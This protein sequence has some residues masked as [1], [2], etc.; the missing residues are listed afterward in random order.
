[1]TRA[2]TPSGSSS[3]TLGPS[4]SRSSGST[5]MSRRGVPLRAHGGRRRG[6]GSR[7][8]TC[9][10]SPTSR[11]RT[12]SPASLLQPL[13]LLA[14]RPRVPAGGGA[15]RPGRC[16]RLDPRH[17]HGRTHHRPDQYGRIRPRADR[18][19]PDQAGVC[20]RF[21]RGLGRRG[22]VTRRDLLLHVAELDRWSASCA[23]VDEAQ[24]VP[25]RAAAPPRRACA[26]RP[27]EDRTEGRTEDRTGQNHLGVRVRRH[28][29]ARRGGASSG[30]AAVPSH[31]PVQAGARP[32]GHAPTHRNER[33]AGDDRPR[34]G[35]R[36][37]RGARPRRQR[38]RRLLRPDARC[39][40]GDP[41]GRAA[42]RSERP[43]GLGR[44]VKVATQTPP[45]RS[46]HRV[47]FL[48][49]DDATGPVDL[50]FFED[51]QGPTPRRSS[52]PGC[53]C[54][55]ASCGAP[56]PGPAS[57]RTAGAWELRAPCR[58][59]GPQGDRRRM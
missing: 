3:T 41:G 57:G 13:R 37:A 15:S 32:R 4:A 18:Y 28:P 55:A 34:A 19:R 35:A 50:T 56:G 17:R 52:T 30:P 7:W 6:S 47:I 16:L 12:S 49:L 43:R 25:Q 36:G 11:S 39:A 58:R 42:V 20:C 5:S 59:P 22:R 51:V 26:L 10:A 45:I 54:A 46:G 53:S 29:G 24:P 44:G 23:P 40:G 33:P 8:P 38:S 31:V 14:T 27:T 1:M 9:T 2:C 48:T 21:P